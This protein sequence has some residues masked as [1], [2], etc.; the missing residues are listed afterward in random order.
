MAASTFGTAR[1]RTGSNPMVTSALTSSLTT[2]V[3]I[4]AA[5]ADPERPAT[6]MAVMMG[7]SSRTMAMVTRL[8]T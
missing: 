7:P 2:M 1:N 4:S 8:A 3:P 5:K 6:R